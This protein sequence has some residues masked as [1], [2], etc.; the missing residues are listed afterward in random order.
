MNWIL[1]F[2]FLIFILSAC[3]TK[4][5]V[6][7]KD[8]SVFLSDPTRNEKQLKKIA[9]ES[10]FWQNRLSKDT[11]NPFMPSAFKRPK[12]LILR[13]IFPYLRMR[14]HSTASMRHG[15]IY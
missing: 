13:F 4:K 11:G 7:S 6:N 12:T 3:G 10:E 1:H 8:Y 14:S 15:K 9:A 5:V 2:V